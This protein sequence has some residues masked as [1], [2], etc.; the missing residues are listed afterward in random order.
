MFEMFLQALL[1][2][3]IFAGFAAFFIAPAVMVVKKGGKTH[4]KWGKIYLYAMTVVALTALI[5]AGFRPNLFLFFIAIFSYYFAF[6]GYRVLRRKRPDKGQKAEAIDWG[7][8]IAAFLVCSGML[9]WGASH[10]FAQNWGF[11][12]ILLTF[13][14]IGSVGV[15]TDMR[16]FIRPSQDKNAWWFDHMGG[17]VGSY[18]AAVTAFSVQ[19]FSFLPSVARWL[20]PAFVGGIGLTIWIRHYKVKFAGRQKAVS[21]PAI[22]YKENLPPKIYENTE[23]RRKEFLL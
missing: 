23:S 7:I 15:A 13:G 14:G 9:V 2:L 1:W 5:L 19:N 17:M 4:R 11:A 12:A 6:S 8:A 22:S 3:H 10:A 16:K 21:L 20:W 18:I